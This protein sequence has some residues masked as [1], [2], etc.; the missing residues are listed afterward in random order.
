MLGMKKKISHA[1][2]K[3]HKGYTIS[4]KAFDC[5]AERAIKMSQILKQRVS[6]LYQETQFIK[7]SK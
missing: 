3:L 6:P 1:I 4:I 2:E 7:F 5:Y